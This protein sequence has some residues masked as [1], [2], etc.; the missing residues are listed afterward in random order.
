MRIGLS[1]IGVAKKS[2]WRRNDGACDHQFFAGHV[3]H[4]EEEI[5]LDDY[6]SRIIFV[7][8]QPFGRYEN[9]RILSDGIACNQDE[10]GQEFYL[11]KKG[12]FDDNTYS[13]LASFK[14]YVNEC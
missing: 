3:D 12:C 7:F 9:G 11:H 1:R 8:I 6:Q 4:L 10:K 2:S 13:V 14:I 5:D